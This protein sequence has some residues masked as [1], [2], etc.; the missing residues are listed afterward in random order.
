MTSLCTLSFI[1]VA[2]LLVTAH[3]RSNDTL[4]RSAQ[5][6]A[7][8]RPIVRSFRENFQPHH[9]SGQSILFLFAIPN[10]SNCHPMSP[11]QTTHSSGCN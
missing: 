11:T 9:A 8:D 4:I 2:L 3:A 10:L 5:G 6:S 1:C 7:Y